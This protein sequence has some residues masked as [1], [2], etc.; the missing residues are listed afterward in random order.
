VKNRP[1]THVKSG[2]RTPRRERAAHANYFRG[3][4]ARM[5]IRRVVSLLSVGLV[6][7]AT[8]VAAAPKKGKV[9]PAKDAKGSGSATGS[10]SGSSTTSSTTV[11]ADATAGA[12][13]SVQMTEDAPPK[14]MNGTD[15]NPDAPRDSRA[16]VGVTA[17]A[18]P[19]EPGY[20]MEEVLRPITLP[21]GMFEVSLAPHFEVSD[22]ARYGF[23]GSEVLRARYGITP[24]IQVGLTYVVGAGYHDPDPGG[25]MSLGYHEGKAVGLDVTYL[26]LNWVGVRLGIPFYLSPVA[27]SLQIGAPLK[28][29]FGDKFAIGGMDDLL[30]IKLAKFAP[31]FYYEYDNAQAAQA[32]QSMVN[33]VEPAGYLR[34]TVFGIYQVDK[35]LA[36]LGRFGLQYA[37]GGN[38]ASTAGAGQP[39]ASTAF[40]RAGVEYTLKKY[41]DLGGT[42]GFD[43]LSQGGS[44]G[45][46]F[47]VAF[48]I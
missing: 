14:D 6:A 39:S 8:F 37:L 43:D 42:L 36:I 12:G 47:F 10:G 23:S 41:L 48:R 16:P 7:S 31:S 4:V 40:V 46:Q 9:A 32:I 25:T 2:P 38:G 17:K 19:R 5:S 30:N 3:I 28:F 13:S 24:K 29:V 11:G 44:F 20:P 27:A 22:P 21:Q 1:R 45:P 15:E 35:Q 18:T 34:L 33:P 26:L